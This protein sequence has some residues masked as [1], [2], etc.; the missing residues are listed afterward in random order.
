MMSRLSLFL[1]TVLAALGPVR[2]QLPSSDVSMG[3]FPFLVG[4]MDG[5]IGEIVTNC[6]Q[7]GID[8]VYVSAFRATG[9]QQGDLWIT[10]RTGTWNPAWG[11]VR[12][13]G[14]GIDLQALITACHAQNLRV[15]AVLKC[16]NDNVQPTHAGHK[17][18]L[19]QVLDHL[20]NSYQS[21]GLPVYDLDGVALDYIRFVSSTTG[22]DPLQVTNF[23][24]SVRTVIRSLSLHC[25]LIASRYTFD[26]GSYNGQFVSYSSVIASLASQYGQ[27]W[28]QMA[29]HV[30]VLMPMS[31]TADGSIYN[32]FPLHQAYVRQTALYARQACT[33]AGFPFRR[34]CPTIRTY[35]DS[36]ETCTPLTIEASIT[37]ALLG[38][39]D[40]YQSF[41]YQT[42]LNQ[43]TWWQKFAQYAVPGPNWPVPLLTVSHYAVT[44]TWNPTLSRDL[45]QPGGTLQVRYDLD[46]DGAFDT[47][48]LPSLQGTHLARHPGTFRAAMQVKDAQGHTSATRRRFTAQG[49]VSLQPSAVSSGFGGISQVRIDAGPAAANATYLVLATLSGTSPGFTWRPGYPVPINIDWVTTAFLSDPNGAVLANGLGTLDGL[50]RGTATLQVPPGLLHPL[51]GATVH[52]SVISQDLFGR[53]T[54]VGEA[55][56]MLILP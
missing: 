34:V 6:V 39:A 47:G 43:P 15:V 49:V 25:Y 55:D 38:G 36:N 4:N 8:T 11:P 2:A 20:C 26:G 46:D 42:M 28:E 56:P 48:W 32:T 50:G 12:P 17:A 54:F 18:Y 40:G 37:G 27:H 21:N 14:A 9:P 5:R 23:L 13:G 45:D 29:R 33:A 44:G 16:F 3:V 35:N 51:I 7:N 41:R 10:D 31:Y 53:P 1:A 30:D 19:L 22:N 24:A 52:W